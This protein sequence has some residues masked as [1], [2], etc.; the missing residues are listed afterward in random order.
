MKQE[1]K[2]FHL[3]I[4]MAGAVSAGAY[5]AGVIDYLLETLQAWQEAKDKNRKLGPQH[6]EYDHSIPMHEVVI[7]AMGGSSAGGMT[8]AITGLSL[9]E[10]VDLE[11]WDLNK[12]KLYDAWVNLN[13]Q[14]SEQPTLLQ[15]LDTAD[16]TS[17]EELPSLLNSSPIDQIADRASLLK[18]TGNLPNYISRDLEIILTITSLRGIP[19]AVNFFDTMEKEEEQK[20]V[21]QHPLPA[22]KMYLHKGIA[23]FQFDIDS[24][25]TP[26]H[27][28]PFHPEQK[29][30]VD[31]LLECA[32]ATGAFPIGL[33]ARKLEGINL[34]YIKNMTYRM[35]G[36]DPNN[37]QNN[38][39]I[40][41]QSETDPFDLM[42][43]DGGTVNNEPFG[44]IIRSLEDKHGA[45]NNNHA[46]VMIDPFPNF[47]MGKEGQKEVRHPS[48]VIEVL[49][50][51]LGAIRAQ[52]M[53]KEKEIVRGLSS[54]YTRKMVFPKKEGDPYP[55]ACGALDGFGGFFSKQ[56]REHDYH[57]GRRNCQ[58]FLRK[59]MSIRLDKAKSHYLFQDWKQDGSDARHNRF[60]VK[61]SEKEGDGAYP[62]IPD[63]GIESM[64]RELFYDP[65][66]KEPE[67]PS[68]TADEIF[69]LD[70]PIQKRLQ[71]VLTY[72]FKT[73][74]ETVDQYQPETRAAISQL[75]DQ[76]FKRDTF[77]SRMI[78]R[79]VIYLWTR[80]GTKALAK[81]LSQKVIGEILLDFKKRGLLKEES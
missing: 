39:G 11:E 55:I 2:V 77:W 68:I 47:E 14:Q 75:L 53:V 36:L 42:A 62:I 73:D 21:D 51:L 64:S 35:F 81:R 38:A 80:F 50:N 30:A 32:K 79:L 74:Q 28:V 44:E 7:D 19:I 34:D 25:G 58:R 65:Y 22:H 9:F 33:R 5:T 60:Y 71:K 61:Y 16:I 8:A 72:L 49:P 4:A 69:A 48:N 57:L 56:F 59:H 6:P 46:V 52:A 67:K 24:Q 63:L 3:G 54:D 40:E 26:S 23:H 41:I 18:K 15:L 20:Q 31:L 29:W 27:T 13:D 70:K 66:M 43:V 10:G 78:S 1:D 45:G 17:A 76:H 37:V 12:K